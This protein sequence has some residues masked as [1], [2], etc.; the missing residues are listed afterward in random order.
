MTKKQKII[1][2]QKL[3]KG[4]SIPKES[5]TKTVTL[6][7]SRETPGFFPREK[8]QV[9]DYLT[10]EEKADNVEWTIQ[11]VKIICPHHDKVK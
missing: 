7:E 8:W 4:E 9:E 3:V 10:D 6:V 2:L 1:L 11:V 5:K